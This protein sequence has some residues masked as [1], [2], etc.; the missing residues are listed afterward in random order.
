MLHFRVSNLTPCLCVCVCMQDGVHAGCVV[1][2]C[3]CMCSTGMLI[4]SPVG[5]CNH[6]INQSDNG[7]YDYGMP[8]WVRNNL[9]LRW[10]YTLTGNRNGVTPVSQEVK[11]WSQLKPQ[12]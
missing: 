12:F 8:E 2:M 4:L 9:K 7:H 5:L 11:C 3:V 10:V 6:S 1:Y